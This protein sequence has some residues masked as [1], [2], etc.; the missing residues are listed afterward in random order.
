VDEEEPVQMK[1]GAMDAF[2]QDQ[3]EKPP[4]KH[5]NRHCGWVYKATMDANGSLHTETRKKWEDVSDEEEPVCQGGD[6]QKGSCTVYQTPIARK[7]H[8]FFQEKSI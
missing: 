2:A 5:H 3:E 7:Y 8:R 1:H 6:P 4:Q